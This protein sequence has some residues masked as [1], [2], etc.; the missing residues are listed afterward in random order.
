MMYGL[1]DQK[2]KR[3]AEEFVF[4]LE[5]ELKRN[6]PYSE[7]KQKIEQRIQLCKSYLRNGDNKEDFDK[8]GAILYGYVAVLKVMSRFTPR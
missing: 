1:E 7:M 2:K 3:K 8:I 5:K 4:E 6:K